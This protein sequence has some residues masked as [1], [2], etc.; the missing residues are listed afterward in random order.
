M[1]SSQEP[2]ERPAISQVGARGPERGQQRPASC[3][4]LMGKCLRE[5]AWS[6]GTGSGMAG[7]ERAASENWPPQSVP[8]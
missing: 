8:V 4:G 7:Q 1:R 2:L 6:L 3:L 5:Q